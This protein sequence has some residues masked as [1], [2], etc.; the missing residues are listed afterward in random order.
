M[1]APIPR[2]GAWRLVAGLLAG[3]L[4][5]CGGGDAGRVAGDV[6]R[7]LSFRELFRLGGVSPAPA[8]QFG[9][10][11]FVARRGPGGAV[12][13]LDLQGEDVRAF[14]AAGAMVHR[15]GGHGNGPGELSGALA[16]GVDSRG[17]V[18]VSQPFQYRY[19]VFDSSGAF[20][21]TVPRPRAPTSLP[22][23]PTGL[24]FLGDGTFIDETAS[25][26]TVIFVRR[27]TMGTMLETHPLLV[28]PGYPRFFISPVLD[29]E[30]RAL[31]HEA[32][33]FL[34]GV[35][36]AIAPDGTVWYSEQGRLVLHHLSL[37]GDTLATVTGPHRAREISA[38]I[39]KAFRAVGAHPG[40]F[41]LAFPEVQAIRVGDD[42]RVMVQIAA[43]ANEDG[44]VFDVFSP[45]GAYLGHVDVHL[46]IPARGFP[47]LFGD[48]IVGVGLDERA[49][50]YL[51]RGV[52]DVH[53]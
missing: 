17:R 13:V 22:R 38:R 8:Y 5:A 10:G 28:R 36:W 46:R 41:R 25:G 45:D 51:V 11:L 7:A 14:D 34:P 3:L 20:L 42:G 52:V 31:L 26:D 44:R 16:M 53:R 49:A 15:F 33:A 23:L 35:V 1:G 30:S 9:G 29:P 32:M 43:E 27:D 40:D 12:Y 37:A 47:A 48:T 19:T 6:G 18:W 39:S 4:A 24:V 21:R 2:P 50:P